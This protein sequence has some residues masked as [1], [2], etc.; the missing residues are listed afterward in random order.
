MEA[1]HNACGEGSLFGA[2]WFLR[3][4]VRVSLGW[5]AP[6]RVLVWEGEGWDPLGGKKLAIVLT[7][8]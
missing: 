6:G 5:G 8:R 4:H 2:P 7:V 3:W 1:E